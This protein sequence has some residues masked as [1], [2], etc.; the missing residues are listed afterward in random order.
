M[1][2][3][4]LIGLVALLISIYIMWK[5]RQVVLLAF[6]AV[7]LATVL[8]RAIIQ[9]QKFKIKRSLAI[10]LTFLILL[11]ILG[12]FSLVIFPPFIEQFQQLINTVPQGIERLDEFRQILPQPLQKSLTDTINQLVRSIRLTD[13]RIF[14]NFFA[15]FSGTFNVVISTL[16]VL[17]LIIM[18]ITNP[19]QY[20]QAF[21]LLFPHSFRPRADEVLTHCEQSLASWF[22]GIIFN[23]TVIT[24]LSGIGLWIL[25]VPL[26]L[27]NACLAG[28]MTFIPNVGP[29]LSVIP[30]IAI[31]LL[32]APWKALAVLILYVIIQ[33]IES[34]ILTP[35]V[36]QKQVSLLPAATLIAQVAFATFFGF[37]GL[38]LALPLTII[39]QVLLQEI[40]IKDVLNNA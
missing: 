29:T 34:N 17:V 15:L 30:P 20:R 6:T 14:G 23:M 8:N 31:A 7:I 19:S 16:L 27:A 11:I 21:I 12:I 39:G 24:L 3:S 33:Q 38:F 22:I 18:L 26:A 4:K 25:G 40:L 1:K 5:I 37:L 13:S 32:E 35:V 9:L 28:L 36:M 10:L 2:L